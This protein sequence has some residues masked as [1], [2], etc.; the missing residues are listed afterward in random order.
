MDAT[1]DYEELCRLEPRLLELQADVEAVTDDGAAS[2]FCSNFEWMPMLGRLKE[3]VGVA[4]LRTKDSDPEIDRVLRDSRAFEA[5]FEA[6]S[7]RMPPCRDC[8]CRGFAPVREAQL[9]G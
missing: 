2:F 4:R 3:L 5:A 6:L 9:G 1:P 8:G 7:R